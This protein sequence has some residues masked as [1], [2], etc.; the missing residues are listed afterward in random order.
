MYGKAPGL[1]SLPPGCPPKYPEAGLSNITTQPTAPQASCGRSAWRRWGTLLEV[2]N[3][4]RKNP[5]PGWY[6]F[7]PRMPQGAAAVCTGGQ[8]Q[9][10]RITHNAPNHPGTDLG[11]FADPSQQYRA[12]PS[13][14]FGSKRPGGCHWP[15][16]KKSHPG[17]IHETK[18]GWPQ[19]G[20]HGC[21]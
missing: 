14:A 4:C 6:F 17:P 7:L 3:L 8:R 1:E 12:V 20:A 2:R 21:L 15:Q 18:K 5:R 19:L 11:P 9:V 13:G 16:R 10:V